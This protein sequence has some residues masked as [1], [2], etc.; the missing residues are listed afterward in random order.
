VLGREKEERRKERE[1]EVGES[2]AAVA[3][4]APAGAFFLSETPRRFPSRAL[5][6]RPAREAR[7]REERSLGFF[8]LGQGRFDPADRRASPSDADPTARDTWLQSG[9]AASGPWA[10]AE[11]GRVPGGVS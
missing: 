7:E 9:V 6:R 2:Q 10:A 8:R 4:R 11:L 3:G 1:R 5:S